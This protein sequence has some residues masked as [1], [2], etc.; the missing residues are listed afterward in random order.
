MQ[1]DEAFAASRRTCAKIYE[2]VSSLPP[3]VQLLP[4]YKTFFSCVSVAL[5]I[6][7]GSL[8]VAGNSRPAKSHVGKHRL[9]PVC[10]P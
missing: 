4:L 6:V 10:S 7:A 5:E 2:L 8:L 3:A 1:S 9:P